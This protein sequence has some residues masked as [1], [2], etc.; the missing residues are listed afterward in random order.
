MAA[1]RPLNPLSSRERDRERG[2]LKPMC[3]SIN[4]S[5]L[6]FSPHPGPLPEGEGENRGLR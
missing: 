2:E 4:E 3:G 5:R 1:A 6:E